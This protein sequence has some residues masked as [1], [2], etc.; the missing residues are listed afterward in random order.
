MFYE[1]VKTLCDSK[2]V[3]ITALARQLHLS[4]SAPNNWREGSLPKAE[5]IMKI[6]EYF[7]VS[8]DFLL[9]GAEKGKTSTSHVSE[10]A[11]VLQH[12]TGN[13]VSVSNSRGEVDKLD[14][15]EAELL[16]IYRKLDM[17]SKSAMLQAAYEIE[18]QA[19]V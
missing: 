5:T 12:S 1:Q 3:A 2:R 6:A 16:R 13:S 19:G 9:Y 15:F 11:A 10:G 18:E 8:T 4:P 14:G 17:K 7:D